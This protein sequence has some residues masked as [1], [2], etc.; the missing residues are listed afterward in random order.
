MEIKCHEYVF[1]E[2]FATKQPKFHCNHIESV[3]T[4]QRGFLAP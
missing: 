2:T 3:F 1:T 4:Q